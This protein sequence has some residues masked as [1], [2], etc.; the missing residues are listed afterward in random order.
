M[1]KQTKNYDL[2]KLLKPHAN[3]WV[4]LSRDQRKVLASGDNLK[5]VAT[6]IKEQDAVFMKVLPPD[7]FYVPC[8]V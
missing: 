8:F 5:E 4:A 1:N 3:Q 6:K 2:R 7:V